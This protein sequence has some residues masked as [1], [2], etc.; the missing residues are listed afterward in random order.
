M[1]PKRLLFDPD[2][3]LWL[4]Q[5]AAK[6]VPGLT[7]EPHRGENIILVWK[8]GVRQT[9]FGFESGSHWKR[10]Q[11][12]CREAAS[13]FQATKARTVFFRTPELGPIPGRWKV[14][15]EIESAKKSYLE[16]LCLTK[17]EVAELYAA[18]ELYAEAMQGNIPF[19]G[20]EALRL[21]AAKLNPWWERLIG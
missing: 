10:W 20:D 19:S 14:A 2:T 8:S 16:I 17:P 9:L 18:R 7:I 1:K 13:C 3:L 11:V 21:L 12:I 5:E 4:V 15:D 6:C